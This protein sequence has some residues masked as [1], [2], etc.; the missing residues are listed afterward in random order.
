MDSV[1]FWMSTGAAGDDEVIAGL[2]RF[3]R[4]PGLSETAGIGPFGGKYLPRPVFVL[5]GQVKPRVRILELEGS[6]IAFE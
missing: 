5:D 2:E 1:F 6:D 4:K 3:G